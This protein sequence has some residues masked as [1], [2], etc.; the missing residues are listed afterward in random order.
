MHTRRAGHVVAE[1]RRYAYLIMRTLLLGIPLCVQAVAAAQEHGIA[2]VDNIGWSELERF[3]LSV[4]IE[5]SSDPIR[6]SLSVSR[7]FPCELRSVSV[8]TFDGPY[9][10]LA[11][12]IAPENGKY[13]FQLLAKYAARTRID[14]DCSGRSASGAV[15]YVL[16][17]SGLPP[18]A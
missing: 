6:V 13:E 1:L 9:P 16:D 4:S 15:G 11:A 17:L 7:R 18:D 12:S 2:R 3:G 10:I 5:R 14:F 8:A